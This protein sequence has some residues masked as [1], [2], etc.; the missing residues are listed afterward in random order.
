MLK[1]IQ[2]R[3]SKSQIMHTKTLQRIS[4]EAKTKNEFVANKMVEVREKIIKEEQDYI[5]NYEAQQ[6]QIR[7][8][9]KNAYEDA[10]YMFEVIKYERKA[11]MQSNIKKKSL[12]HA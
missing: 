4:M 10:Q 8:K 5:L 11:R 6:K 12:D 9:L 2:D 1:V 3:M 7:K